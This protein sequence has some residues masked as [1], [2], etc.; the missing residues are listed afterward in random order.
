M[1]V[2]V[3]MAC[4][5]AVAYDPAGESPRCET[6]AVTRVSRV[7]APE[8]PRIRSVDCDATGPYVTK[9]Q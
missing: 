3:R 4:G 7:L 9:E 1:A 8:P 6:H 2:T 5:C